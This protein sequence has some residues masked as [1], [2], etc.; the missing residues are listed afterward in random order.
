M[1]SRKPQ[2]DQFGSLNPEKFISQAHNTTK[3]ALPQTETLKIE[4]LEKRKQIASFSLSGS[5]MTWIE[6]SLVELNNMTQKKI[7]R[8]DI[9]SAG[10][11][12]LQQKT[13]E[14][15]LQIIKNM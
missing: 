12:T 9:I 11:A 1:L 4:K 7:T 10:L 5:E 3:P 8:T 14:E 15:I 13:L 2:S 6:S